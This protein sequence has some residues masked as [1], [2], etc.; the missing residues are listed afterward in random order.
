MNF[1]VP[2]IQTIIDEAEKLGSP[3]KERVLGLAQDWLEWCKE[4]LSETQ[5]GVE[6]AKTLTLGGKAVAQLDAIEEILRLPLCQQCKKMIA[7]DHFSGK[8]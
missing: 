1:S 4:S 6:L 8:M 2:S 7:G 5:K 3:W